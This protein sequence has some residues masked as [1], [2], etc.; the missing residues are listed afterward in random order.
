MNHRLG[1]VRRSRCETR[2]Y[3]GKQYPVGVVSYPMLQ[4]FLD[5]LR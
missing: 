1:L 3:N 4:K 2:S 5:S